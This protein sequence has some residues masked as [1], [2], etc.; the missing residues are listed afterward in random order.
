MR[1]YLI[2]HA[3]T[4]W[5]ATSKAQGWS[6]VPLD[7]LGH[8]QARL[9]AAALA[10]ASID[11]VIAS[12]LKRA[13]QTAEPLAEAAGA[14]LR[15][16]SRLRERGFGEWEGWGFETIAER[17][18]EETRM[19]GTPRHEIR[20][21]GGESFVDVWNRMDSVVSELLEQGGTT[22]VVTHGGTL[23][24]LLARLIGGSYDTQRAF[25]FG[26]ASITELFSR[27]DGSLMMLRYNDVLHLPAAPPVATAGSAA[28][29]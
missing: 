9:L 1:L 15:L 16:D 8:Q 12:D 6:D 29:R 3:Q 27:P 5:N 23:S 28:A 20:P 22:A 11:H 7:D 14:P 24:V 25:R 21:P 10:P 26:N 17:M 18:R 19:I 13:A 2:R 4:A